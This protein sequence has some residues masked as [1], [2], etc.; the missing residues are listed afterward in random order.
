V[1]TAI[2]P[3]V[4]VPVLSNTTVS[5]TPEDSS[6]WWPLTKMPSCAPRPQAAT[7]AAGVARPSAHGHA[8]ISTASPALNACSAAAPASSQP[9]SVSAWPDGGN[10][11]DGQRQAGSLFRP[12]RSGPP[13]S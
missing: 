11:L 7:R 2:W 5:I 8:M 12:T 9:A 1:V 13:G 10:E 3:V 6:A 4:T